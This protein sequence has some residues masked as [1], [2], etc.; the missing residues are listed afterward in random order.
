MR[1]KPPRL[2]RSSLAF[3]ALVGS[4]EITRQTH[5]VETE[6]PNDFES[7]NLKAPCQKA[8][9]ESCLSHGTSHRTAD[10]TALAGHGEP[11]RS[12]SST[13]ATRA[14]S[15]P[16]PSPHDARLRVLYD[17]S[18]Y[19]CAGSFGA[20]VSARCLLRQSNLHSPRFNPAT[21]RTPPIH[22]P[23]LCGSSRS[24]PPASKDEVRLTERRSRSK[25]PMR[26]TKK[27]FR[28]PVA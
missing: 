10:S 23:T 24:R 18:S 20:R 2:S 7:D 5:L 12:S 15:G 17:G 26:P 14:R 21:R 16:A 11:T 1:Q 27:R 9:P 13:A 4:Y 3:F 6:F 28:S 25:S 19:A 22:C 8:A